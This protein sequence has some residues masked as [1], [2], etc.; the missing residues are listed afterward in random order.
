MQYVG[1]HPSQFCV[2]VQWYTI[3][4]MMGNWDGAA[5]TL[6][7]NV[8]M[9]SSNWCSGIGDSEESKTPEECGGICIR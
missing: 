9:H 8:S 6:M 2:M 5:V 1:C 4:T 7:C 3:G